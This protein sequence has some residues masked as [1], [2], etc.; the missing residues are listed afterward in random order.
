M[1]FRQDIGNFRDQILCIL[2]AVFISRF[3]RNYKVF[4][5]NEYHTEWVDNPF[6]DEKSMAK[7]YLNRF[8]IEEEHQFEIHV[9][10]ENDELFDRDEDI[11][12]VAEELLLK[13]QQGSSEFD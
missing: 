10:Y 1:T 4:I 7:I 9:K 6:K 5:L 2:N 11:K 3:S 13:A 12:N 8:A